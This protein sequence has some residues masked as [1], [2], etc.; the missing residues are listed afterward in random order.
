MVWEGEGLLPDQL[1]I[2]P[3]MSVVHARRCLRLLNIASYLLLREER[4]LFHREQ[5]WLE[6]AKAWADEFAERFQFAGITVSTDKAA[7]ASE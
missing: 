2:Y 3:L 5:A 7:E 6:A 1:S 4:E